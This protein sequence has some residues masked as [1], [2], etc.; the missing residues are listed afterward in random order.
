MVLP[1]LELASATLTKTNP[2][3]ILL[4]I[5]TP[6]IINIISPINSPTQIIQE[7]AFLENITNPNQTTPN[8]EII[9][10]IIFDKSAG[11][12]WIESFSNPMEK[13]IANNILNNLKVNSVPEFELATK[14]TAENISTALGDEP[15]AFLFDFDTGKSKRWLFETHNQ[16]LKKQPNYA[17]YFSK[18]HHTKIIDELSNSGINTFVIW[19]DA[20]YS[21]DDAV[22]RFID[23]INSK[24]VGKEVKPKI[25]VAY[26]YYTD[27]AK[28]AITSNE[29]VIF[30]GTKRMTTVSEILTPEQK[31]FL[32]GRSLLSDGTEVLT[33]LSTETMP[34]KIPDDHSLV[35]ANKLMEKKV[36]VGEP[37]YKDIT[38]T[39]FQNE[40]TQFGEYFE[41]GPKNLIETPISEI[42][43]NNLNSN[44]IINL[45]KNSIVPNTE[46]IVGCSVQTQTNQITK[47]NETGILAKQTANNVAVDMSRVESIELDLAD[48]EPIFLDNK[49]K[50]MLFDEIQGTTKGL[51]LSSQEAITQTISK[52]KIG[53]IN[54]SNAILEI[55]QQIPNNSYLRTPDVIAKKIMYKFSQN[56]NAAL[57]FSNKEG[58]FYLSDGLKIG[59]ESSN[60]LILDSVKISRAQAKISFDGKSTFLEN[61]GNGKIKLN[62]NIITERTM[63]NEGDV[64]SFGE[65][66]DVFQISSPKKYILR[67]KG[68]ELEIGPN[69]G[70]ARIGRNSDQYNKNVISTSDPRSSKRHA[71][72]YYSR[73][74]GE[75]IVVDR[76]S[77]SGT[78]LNGKPLITNGSAILEDGDIIRVASEEIVVLT[79]STSNPI[80][81]ESINQIIPKELLPETVPEEKI[82]FMTQ[83]E[84]LIFRNLKGSLCT[85][86]GCYSPTTKRITI[87]VD[88]P[89]YL[90]NG[91][92]NV[93]KVKA[94][95]KHEKTHRAWDFGDLVKKE[96]IIQKI[97]T[98]PAR[99]ERKRQFLIFWP[100][101][102]TNPDKTIVNEMIARVVG[103]QIFPS[104]HDA[105]MDVMNTQIKPIVTEEVIAF[106][107][108][109]DYRFKQGLASAGGEDIALGDFKYEP[110]LESLDD[111]PALVESEELEVALSFSRDPSIWDNGAQVKIIE[112][113]SKLKLTGDFSKIGGVRV[114]G[115]DSAQ[116]SLNGIVYAL[117]NVP[118]LEPKYIIQIEEAMKQNKRI[119]AIEQK[120]H[121]DN[122]I[123]FYFPKNSMVTSSDL[124]DF[125]MDELSQYRNNLTL[126]K[127]KEIISKY[128][129][130]TP[131]KERIIYWVDKSI[132]YNNQD[133]DR[134]FANGMDST[135]V[136]T[137]K[138]T[139]SLF[140]GTKYISPT[141][142]E[143]TSQEAMD[144]AWKNKE[145]LRPLQ[146]YK[147]Q[148][149]KIKANLI[150][151]IV[152]TT[153][154]NPAIIKSGFREIGMKKLVSGN[155]KD[156]LLQ[157]N[158]F[159]NM[160]DKLK[161]IDQTLANKPTK[162]K[163]LCIS[164]KNYDDP[165]L[166]LAFSD[167][168]SKV[169]IN[170]FLNQG[171][172]QENI[173]GITD[174]TK[175]TFLTNLKN[176]TQTIKSDETLIL[177][178]AGHTYT[179]SGLFSGELKNNFYFAPKNTIPPNE[180]NFFNS[181]KITDFGSE[182]LAQHVQK[183]SDARNIIP[184]NE[185]GNILQTMQG[186]IVFI[187]DS[188]YSGN[189]CEILSTQLDN[190]IFIGSTK[191]GELAVEKEELQN[192][193]WTAI[194]KDPHIIRTKSFTDR[195]SAFSI[196]PITNKKISYYDATMEY[197]DPN[198]VNL[199]SE[200]IIFA[201]KS[202]GL[203]SAYNEQT[204]GTIISKSTD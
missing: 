65:D 148:L 131:D 48:F 42:K 78:F 191:T 32:A 92:I 171:I 178:Y 81:I 103:Y 197:F 86:R 51:S 203:G 60:D 115:Y 110:F 100:Q 85:S 200:R 153:Q 165:N 99:P 113:F 157:L 43:I 9:N 107:N 26:S 23:V 127:T 57:V 160:S 180:I 188:C 96:Q 36:L 193:V 19:D 80:K 135:N 187:A 104:Q 116:V 90:D 182:D 125:A 27:T 37:V 196:D 144:L 12:S 151:D 38:T 177:F 54:Y 152:N 172:P 56:E 52:Y 6:K 147:T 124:A 41:N 28:K 4:K 181:T 128:N 101:Y 91:Q 168:D 17:T 102:A 1:N 25:I 66:S 140:G 142:Q 149:E 139:S 16:Y 189:T 34:Y 67:G 46:C 166:N 2:T 106:L 89:Y 112:N 159:D 145:M 30:I 111:Y 137:W 5:Y 164:Q 47:I 69:S 49:E 35:A 14:Q 71:Y 186:N 84:F 83:E 150:E 126:D 190:G 199:F 202:V 136:A 50:M 98:D 114:I 194:F 59:R 161:S 122:V 31:T 109:G 18:N 198:I 95:L 146:N 192:G 119:F 11:Q 13:Q 175:E 20:T 87:P 156:P 155:K 130:T 120:L 158:Q 74:K 24:Y 118:A 133:I 195:Y 29:N 129:L 132:E 44:Q 170:Y 72:V 204:A 70:V 97:L 15:S 68:I 154:K 108:E 77:K 141:G 184:I 105:P 58:I 55:S 185:V 63:L 53:T 93:T 73:S 10:S 39:Y 169:M 40:K 201:S 121:G 183:I 173:L 179:E 45:S 123:Y 22:T 167:N 8:I 3:T 82:D 176:I 75:L 76:G 162:V 94:T 174:P 117:K 7:Q 163:V 143:L 64:V 62:E 79:K 138:K 134:F 61:I 33:G 88:N 21:G